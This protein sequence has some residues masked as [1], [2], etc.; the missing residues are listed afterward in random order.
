V[1]VVL[2]HFGRIV[3]VEDLGIVMLACFLS[4]SPAR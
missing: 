1:L 3:Q 4:D 2:E